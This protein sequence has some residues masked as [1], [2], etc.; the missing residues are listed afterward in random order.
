MNREII[1]NLK[2]LQKYNNL[3]NNTWK[4]TAYSKAIRTLNN[5]D[6]EITDSKQVKGLIFIGSK[7]VAK[8]DEF[9]K[10]GKI[11]EVEKAK[12]VLREFKT[13][14]PQKQIDIEKLQLI[15]GIGPKKAEQ[16]YQVGLNTIEKLRKNQIL[17]TKKQKIGLKYYEDLLKKIPRHIIQAIHVYTIIQLN[18]VLGKNSYKFTIAGSYRRGKLESGDIDMLITSEKFKLKDFVELLE[19]KK[20]IV[21][22]ESM[23]DE[24]FMGIIKCPTG[25]GNFMRLD[26]QFIPKESWASALLYF[27]GSA[28]TNMYMRSTAK[29]MGM[30]LNQNG[31]FKN[32]KKLKADTEQ[33]IFNHLNLK[34]LEPKKR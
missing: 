25:Y 27:T 21:V 34:Y 4:A 8:I 29:K 24:K 1:D 16:L 23:R 10:T 33:D 9:L 14:I 17:L 3:Q 13:K 31:L 6:L 7:I 12:S 15:W 5:L 32:G 28:N 2:I 30:V 18:R 11:E 19:E 20:L 22:K 26:I